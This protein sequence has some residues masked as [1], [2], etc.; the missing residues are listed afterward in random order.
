MRTKKLPLP[1]PQPRK[2][3]HHREV[4]YDGYLREDGLWDIEAR[5]TDT[6]TY[7]IDSVG[8]PKLAAG[9]PV[10][11]MLIR[12]TVDDNM[13]IREINV[14]MDSRPFDECIQARDPMQKMVGATMGPGWRYAIEKALGGI[15]GCAH[16]RELL[17]N[18]AT[19]AYQTIPVHRAHQ[20][21]LSNIAPT[22][23]G[24]PPHHLGKCVAWDFNG[25]VV[26][27]NYPAFAGWKALP[28]AG[29]P[30]KD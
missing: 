23:S 5:I 28:E 3:L 12:A 15:Q 29:K 18:M 8:R 11:D 17:F 13:T 9:L 14:A 22:A 27:R 4:Y 24:T 26:R 20:A 30:P 16:L 1:P 21:K 6:R 10:H 19:A 25:P 2:H 7:S